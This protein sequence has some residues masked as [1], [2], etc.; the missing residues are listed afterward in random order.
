MAAT[1]VA[2][3]AGIIALLGLVGKSTVPRNW[4]RTVMA[5]LPAMAVVG[6]PFAAGGW[7]LP[8]ML[9]MTAA[10][11]LGMLA[12]QIGPGEFDTVS[13]DRP[14]QV[15]RAFAAVI[16][17]VALGS[18]VVRWVVSLY[19]PIPILSPTAVGA[20]IVVAAVTAAAGG[21][22]LRGLLGTATVIVLIFAV[23][24]IVVGA[25]AGAPSTLT[26]PLMPVSHSAA[27]WLW[28]LLGFVLAAA[29][30]ALRQVRADGGSI[31]PGTIVVAAVMLGGS[32]AL[33]AFNGGY[34]TLPSF[35]LAIVAG[36][37]GFGTPVPAAVLAV[38]FT[39]VAVGSAVGQYVSAMRSLQ[40]MTAG[41]SAGRGW[42]RER[43]ALSLAV[44]VVAV[45]F[46][47]R[48]VPLEPL[49]WAVA[50]IAASSWIT[51]WW[52][53]RRSGRATAEAARQTVDA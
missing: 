39:I 13:G 49:L 41:D 24:L 34:L 46:V 27:Q 15:W 20:V 17:A 31:L 18:F 33:L 4:Q 47:L 9:G 23:L 29:N 8:V 51:G 43:W 36:Y 53:T 50:L 25:V 28:L 10:V 1:F 45:I 44:G 40:S 6:A 32:V 16:V 38:V 2:V 48:I 19:V 26:D 21:M 37:V 7:N 52:S 42:W 22:A 12:S 3:T 30:P 14:G 5:A 11:V 35:S